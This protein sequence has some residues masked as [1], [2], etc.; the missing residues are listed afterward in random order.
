MAMRIPY[1]SVPVGML[2]A[3]VQIKISNFLSLTDPHPKK[4]LYVP[5]E[6]LS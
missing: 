2:Y 5:E 1:F 3:L 6:M 4:P